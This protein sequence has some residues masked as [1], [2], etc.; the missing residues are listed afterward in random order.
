MPTTRTASRQIRRSRPKSRTLHTR[1]DEELFLRLELK[2]DRERR[3]LS[4]LVRNA[5]E[6]LLVAG[7]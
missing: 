2:A 3:N 4:D 6:T 5:I 7:V 1:L